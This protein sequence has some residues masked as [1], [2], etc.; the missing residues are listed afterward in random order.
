[1]SST[2][3]SIMAPPSTALSITPMAEGS[4]TTYS[5]FWRSWGSALRCA[6][7]NLRDRHHYAFGS[8]KTWPTLKPFIAGR[9]KTALIR[10][11]WDDLLHLASSIRTG[12]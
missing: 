6:S 11:H 5:A 10:D 4:R 7:S 9:V 1:M 8:A 12:E 2:G 3:C